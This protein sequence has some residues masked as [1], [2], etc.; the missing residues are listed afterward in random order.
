MGTHS[1]EGVDEDGF[2]VS[3]A[4][5]ELISAAYEPA[6]DSVVSSLVENVDG[7][8]SVYLYGSVATGEA[9]PPQSDIDVLVV[10]RDD[11][12]SAAVAGRCRQGP[13]VALSPPCPR[14]RHRA[15]NHGRAVR[16]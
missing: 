16:R 6:L 1:R 11:R 14:G 13:V 5:V 8:I 9:C 10:T 4:D 7:Q 3:G 12:S 15:C 2:I